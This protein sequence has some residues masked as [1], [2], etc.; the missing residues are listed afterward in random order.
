M[1]GTTSMHGGDKGE[2]DFM[3]LILVCEGLDW[4]EL[5]QDGYEWGGGL[6]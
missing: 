3:E 6:L 4:I 1:G 2:F 5:I